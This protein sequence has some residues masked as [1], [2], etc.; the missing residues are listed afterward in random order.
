MQMDDTGARIRSIV[1]RAK[2]RTQAAID[3]D[4]RIAHA[5]YQ[6]KND[7]EKHILKEWI[8]DAANISAKGVSMRL[9]AILFVEFVE[10]DVDGDVLAVTMSVTAAKR[11]IESWDRGE[12][13]SPSLAEFC[14]EDH[15]Y[16]QK[17]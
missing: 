9:N 4:L 12:Q 7:R 16:Q 6:S 8:N 17:T 3:N 1:E 2:L 14:G 11:A 5:M 13:Y 15:L 10:P